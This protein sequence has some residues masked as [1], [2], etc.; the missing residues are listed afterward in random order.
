[1][2]LF[3]VVIDNDVRN[4]YNKMLGIEEASIKATH[5][6]NSVTSKQRVVFMW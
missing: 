3:W 4:I 2:G 6:H 5:E 1:M